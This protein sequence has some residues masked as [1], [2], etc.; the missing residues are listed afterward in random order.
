MKDRYEVIY[1]PKGAAAEYAELACNIYDGCPSG[2]RYCYVPDVLR[3]ARARFH[4]QCPPR[5]DILMRIESGL[6]AMREAG[7]TRRV[8]LCFACDPYPGIRMEHETTRRVIELFREFDVRFTL[9]TKNG[10][11]AIRDF[12][13]YVKQGKTRD[14]FGSTL[15]FWSDS[16]SMHWEPKAELPITRV[17]ALKYAAEIG[18]PT[19]V[20]FEPVLDPMQTYTLYDATK[21]FVDEYRIGKINHEARINCTEAERRAL[22]QIDWRRFACEMI[23]RCERDGKKYYIKDDLKKYL[24]E[25]RL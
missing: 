19:W 14:T 5:A 2:C 3:I 23:E 11:A 12:G 13:L 20:S 4:S 16:D 25:E 24:V 1:T 15:T 8:L 10:G 9:L 17:K 6:Y 21:G 22:M 7:D 18:I